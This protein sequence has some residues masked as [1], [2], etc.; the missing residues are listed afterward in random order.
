MLFEVMLDCPWKFLLS[1]MHN[2]AIV[3]QRFKLFAYIQIFGLLLRQTQQIC[4]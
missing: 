1:R 2:L 4:Y 3:M